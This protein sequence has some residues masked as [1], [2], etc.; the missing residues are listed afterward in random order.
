MNEECSLAPP[1][2]AAARAA[3][4]LPPQAGGDAQSGVCPRLRGKWLRSA[5]AA[6]DGGTTAHD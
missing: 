3:Q 5:A 1:S 4:G 2:P 6:D